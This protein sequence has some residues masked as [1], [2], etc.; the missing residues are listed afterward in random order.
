MARRQ[1]EAENHWPG[2]V[3]ALSTIVMVV[4][5]LLIILGVVIFIIAQQIKA[6]VGDSEQKTETT[7][8]Y[9]KPTSAESTEPS[10]QT[11]AVKALAEAAK[12]SAEEAKAKAEQAKAE[13][14]QAKA[15]SEEAKAESEQAKA[16]SEQAKAEAEQAKSE[17]AQAEAEAQAE[18]AKAA[19]AETQLQAQKIEAQKLESKAKITLAEELRQD[20]ETE[21]E[22]NGQKVISQKVDES[23]QITIASEEVAHNF[24]ANIVQNAD[25][26]LTLIFDEK[27][28][29][30]D[31][32]SQT[33]IETFLVEE[34][35]VKQQG[36]VEIRAY[37]DLNQTSMGEARRKA[38]YRAMAARNILLG[39]E[40]EAK[41][42]SIKVVEIDDKKLN[43]ILKIYIKP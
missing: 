9:F 15:E 36:R 42:I 23:K 1:E 24:K 29:T 33:E 39:A 22:I 27:S 30:I 32:S 4:T 35:I 3:D 31:E 25:A 34:N 11:E 19:Q 12:A 16:E 38:F 21:Q 26:I 14:E 5:F 6:S 8:K 7:Q 13:S 28:V 40:I 41:Q 43:G 18:S 17:A 2:F 37:V 20:R 10:Q